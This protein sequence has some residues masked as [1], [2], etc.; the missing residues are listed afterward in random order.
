MI[1]RALFGFLAL[2]H[3]LP[4]V[5]DIV[6]SQLQRLYGIDPANSALVTLLQHRAVLLG[7]VGA[8]FVMATLR[9][10]DAIAWH[11]WMLGVA[12]MTTFLIIA[13][14]N[15]EL[16]GSLRMITIVDAIGLVPLA[17][18]AFRQPSS[19]SV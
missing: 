18:L 13:A 12:S 5:A 1:D 14:V 6:P 2:I 4:T 7:L 3:L 16:T 15:R 17:I 8:G 10:N 19:P 9:P 11:A